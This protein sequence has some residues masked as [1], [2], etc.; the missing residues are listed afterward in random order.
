[1]LTSTES[2]SEP[3][4]SSSR[5]SFSMSLNALPSGARKQTEPVPVGLRFIPASSVIAAVGRENN[6]S[7]FGWAGLSGPGSCP[8]SPSGYLLSCSEISDSWLS[9]RSS[10]GWVENRLFRLK[11]PFSLFLNAGMK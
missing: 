8:G 2:V 7:R 1:M 3:M 5:T 4:D 9:R 6:S 11:L 10:D